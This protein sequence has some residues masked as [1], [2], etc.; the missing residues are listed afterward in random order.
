MVTPDW[1]AREDDADQLL[2]KWK[3]KAESAVQKLE[4]PQPEGS[5]LLENRIPDRNYPP[6]LVAAIAANLLHGDKT[7]DYELAV[8]QALRLLDTTY[9][10]LERPSDEK[11]WERVTWDNAMMEVTGADRPSKGQQRVI[12]RLLKEGLEY[13]DYEALR[14][15]TGP[16]AWE[17]VL[18]NKEQ[19]S[20][21]IPEA[22]KVARGHDPEAEPEIKRRIPTQEQI[23]ADLAECRENG[24]PRWRVQ[25]LSEQYRS[26]TNRIRAKNFS[27]KE[28]KNAT[29]RN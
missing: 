25:V 21:I 13:I 6:E 24:I 19:G 7:N 16:E 11:Q 12:E 10:I 29:K 28:K 2:S 3:D 9:R 22:A 14:E 4:A 1:S 20:G 23:D 27:K 17:K 18:K 26:E 5:A 15:A 8:H